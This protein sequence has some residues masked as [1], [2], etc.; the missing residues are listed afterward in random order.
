ME[1][2]LQRI[3]LPNCGKI[4]KHEFCLYDPENEFTEEKNLFYLNEDL[5][6]IEFEKLNLIL[7]LGWYGEI[8]NNK[9][10]FKIFVV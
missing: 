7:D 9:G 5:L 8:A 6:Q 1:I 10:S 4:I 3:E 2:Q